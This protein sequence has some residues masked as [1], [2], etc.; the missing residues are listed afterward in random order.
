MS[1]SK[2]SQTRSVVSNIH[3]KDIK[4]FQ[5]IFNFLSLYFGSD[6]ELCKV[7]GTNDHGIKSKMKQGL[8]RHSI[9]KK[10]LAEYTKIKSK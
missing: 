9:A 10:L 5:D 7:I 8:L 2:I 1:N 4:K 6:V 3:K